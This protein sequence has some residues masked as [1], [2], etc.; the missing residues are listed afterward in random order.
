M[1]KQVHGPDPT[2]LTDAVTHAVEGVL[3]TDENSTITYVNPAFTTITGYTPED[4]LGRNPRFLSSGEHSREFFDEMW[5]SL[6]SNHQWKGRIRNRRKDGTVYVA[7]M[8]IAAVFNS[9]GIL[10]G[11]LSIALDVTR[12]AQLEERHATHQKLE[13][14]GTLAG[15]IA[16]DFNNILTGIQG[17][18]QLASAMVQS[19][20]PAAKQIEG[21]LTATGSARELIDR[22][23]T[24]S[25][26]KSVERTETD[27]AVVVADATRLLKAAVCKAIQI[28]TRVQEPLPTPLVNATQ[29]VQVVINLGVNP[30]LAI[31]DKPDGKIDITLAAPDDQSAVTLEVVDNGSGMTEEVLQHIYEPFYTTRSDQNGS[32]MG[33]PV[34][35]GIVT[36]YGGTI[37]ISSEVG[38]GTR[39]L[40]TIP[41]ETGGISDE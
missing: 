2:I 4:A 28:E 40:I 20:D 23:L 27:L 15:G 39:V 13:A 6:H 5:N 21:I 14:L 10:R 19:S 11:Y 34:V 18:A 36:D 37:D 31:G 7:E 17:Y 1:T 30:A 16:H 12:E 9:H 24:F 25:R 29:I 3:Y 22:I 8:T 35:H 33:L 32:G 38:I 41:T 26:G